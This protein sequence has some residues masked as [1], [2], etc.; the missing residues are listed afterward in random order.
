MNTKQLNACYNEINHTSKEINM[1]KV[2]CMTPR[3][4]T[5]NGIEK[6]FVNT[7]YINRLTSRGYNTLLLT[8]GNPDQEALFQLCDGF[9]VTGGTD[10]D[11]S[12][13]GELNQGLSLNV[14]A[15]L[16]QL[17]KD[18][19]NYAVTHKVPLLGICRGHQSLNVFL[20]GTLHQDLGDKNKDHQ[21]VEY[22][23][24]I[25]MTPHPYFAWGSEI[26]VNSYHHQAIK[27]LAPNLTVL[28]KHP[29]QTIEM[30]IHNSLPIF[31]VQW[32]PEINFDSAPSKIIFDTF[33]DFIEKRKD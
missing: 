8:L 18:V 20:G 9:L 14:D 33:I 3:L 31:S 32:H 30:V 28:G 12:T 17:D 4:I 15:R 2:I 21:R 5:E 29:D 26:S 22:N 13:Y 27:D 19:I 7:R 11:P 16:D 6:Q 23:H 25:H 24:I 1:S 10:L